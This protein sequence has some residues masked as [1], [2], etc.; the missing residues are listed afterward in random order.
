MP[1]QPLHDILLSNFAGAY[2]NEQQ[3]FSRF[4]HVYMEWC[5]GPD[6]AGFSGYGFK[7]SSA[8]GRSLCEMST[9]GNTTAVVFSFLSSACRITFPG[10]EKVV[11]K[12]QRRT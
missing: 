9:A 10:S 5:L 3:A 12:K 6:A 8:V 11:W 4:D 7:F 1:V 2:Q